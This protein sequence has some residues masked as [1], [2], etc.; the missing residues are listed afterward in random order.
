[1][2]RGG[3]S[4]TGPLSSISA[5]RRERSQAIVWENEPTPE[6]PQVITQRLAIAQAFERDRG[7][8]RVIRRAILTP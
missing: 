5:L 4:V 7:I 1:M 2:V 8:E 6:R 3:S